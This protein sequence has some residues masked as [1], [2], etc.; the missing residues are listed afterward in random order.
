MEPIGENRT[1]L[2]EEDLR[3]C[4]DNWEFIVNKEYTKYG[5]VKSKHLPKYHKQMSNSFGMIVMHS[6]HLAATIKELEGKF[7]K[8]QDQFDKL[9][10]KHNRIYSLYLEL[11][12]HNAKL[13]KD[14]KQFSLI[15]FLTIWVF[16]NLLFVPFFRCQDDS[17]QRGVNDFGSDERADDDAEDDDFD[18][19]DIYWGG[20]R[21]NFGSDDDG[22]CTKEK[23]KVS[24]DILEERDRK[25]KQDD[26][27]K[28]PDGGMDKQKQGGM[29]VES[30][31][32]VHVQC[33]D[34]D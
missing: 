11:K 27:N 22:G 3:D 2:E 25:R 16:C 31:I 12:R 34:V 15:L 14:V 20:A 17:L 21:S 9:Q 32:D 10:D 18:S 28:V 24:M 30:D 19:D 1:P 7:E 5:D 26:D 33:L 8:L 13:D 29:D 4:K 6:A 23:K